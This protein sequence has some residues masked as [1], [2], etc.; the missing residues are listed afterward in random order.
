V[1]LHGGLRHDLGQRVTTY[2]RH[3]E[4]TDVDG[5]EHSVDDDVSLYSFAPGQVDAM[6]GSVGLAGR[7]TSH[8]PAQ[9]WVAR[10][11]GHPSEPGG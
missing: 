9:R 1:T 7:A 5:S 6:L 3:F 4:I 10:R 8:G 2:T 11:I